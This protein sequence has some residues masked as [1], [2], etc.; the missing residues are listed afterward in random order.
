MGADKKMARI[1][2]SRNNDKFFDVIPPKTKSRD[3][4]ALEKSMALGKLVSQ[5]TKI[6][7]ES[8]EIRTKIYNLSQEIHYIED[9]LAELFMEGK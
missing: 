9:E 3:K 6:R 5:R 7:E 2:G 8:R 4:I 1:K